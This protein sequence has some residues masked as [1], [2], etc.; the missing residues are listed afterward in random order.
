M[1]LNELE[2]ITFL[3]EVPL[4]LFKPSLGSARAGWVW[5]AGLASLGSAQQLHSI[6]T[7]FTVVNVIF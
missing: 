5:R 2:E 6:L 7:T 4:Q 1:C 3:V